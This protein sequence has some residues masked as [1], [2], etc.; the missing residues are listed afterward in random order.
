MEPSGR[1]LKAP[2]SVPL[3]IHEKVTRSSITRKNGRSAIG[4]ALALTGRSAALAEPVEA[5]AASDTAAAANSETRE[6]ILNTP[7]LP[8][9]R[10]RPLNV[11]V[12]P[13]VRG[14]KPQLSP[15]HAV[16]F[17]K[18]VAVSASYAGWRRLLR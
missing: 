9:D 10:S 1:T 15:R 3:G 18:N 12:A 13:F 11:T 7:K 8:S 16:S 6:N 5:S 2:G 4:L 17:I 14:E